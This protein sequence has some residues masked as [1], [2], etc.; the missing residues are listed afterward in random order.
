MLLLALTSI[1]QGTDF[2]A[3]VVVTNPGREVAYSN[4]AL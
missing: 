3:K 2:L 1:K 4:M